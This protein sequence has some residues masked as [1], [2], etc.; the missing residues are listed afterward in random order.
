M[1]ASES[2]PQR[3]RAH[4][5]HHGGLG[6]V[7]VCLASPILIATIFSALSPALPSM[8]A[9]YAQGG[10][11]TNIAQ[12]VFSLPAIVMIFGAGFSGFFSERLGRRKVVVASLV[13]YALA[14]A[15]SLL[16]PDLTILA[17]GRAIIGFAGGV[18]LA[19]TYA[20]IGEYFEGD[21]RERLLGFAS[22]AASISSILLFVTGGWL[23]DTFGWRPMLG[24]YL[25]ALPIAPVAW[26]SMH[27]GVAARPT[28][29]PSWRLILPLWRLYLL[30]AA[31]T[32][33]MYVTAIQ[34]PF[35]MAH[36]GITSA[37]TI[38]GLLALSSLFGALGGASYGYMR[39][40]MGFS[41]M[42]VYISLTIGGG[43]ILAATAP[44]MSLLVL[45]AI[46]IGMGIGVIEPTIASEVLKRTPDVLHDRAMGANIAAMFL[47]QFLNPL[48]M[49]PLREAWGIETAFIIVGTVYLAAAAMF[50]MKVLRRAAPRE[51]PI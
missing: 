14:G 21:K 6:V 1:E 2:A 33:G 30:L 43:M 19:A 22:M 41:A 42:F 16:A 50:V 51:H 27:P 29:R 4:V 18:L 32:I 24:V 17:I 48:A 23:V 12:M 44:S 35:L 46:V 25:L 47:G 28:D 3:S 20:V 31:Y 39:R 38:G 37:S 49:R 45:S 10:D 7:V 34:S 11:G 5:P 15:I 9:E 40:R 36:R 8:A 13:L 26:L